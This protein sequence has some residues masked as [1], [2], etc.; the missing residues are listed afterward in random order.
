VSDV[1]LSG[2]SFQICSLTQFLQIYA[3]I[4]R[5]SL[6]QCRLGVNRREIGRV[7]IGTENT[8]AVIR[9]RGKVI[10]TPIVRRVSG[11]KLGNIGCF[12]SN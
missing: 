2:Y 5:I 10:M 6:R 1:L 9:V 3:G 12:S 4:L 11:M 7:V 8:D